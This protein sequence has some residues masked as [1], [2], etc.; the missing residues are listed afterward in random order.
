MDQ[1]YL[2]PSMFLQLKR[3]AARGIFHPAGSC[4]LAL[5]IFFNLVVFQVSD[6]HAQVRRSA[7]VTCDFTFQDTV[8]KNAPV[9]ITNLSQGA[10]N[11]FWQ[12]CPGT[13]LSFPSGISTGSIA[14]KL[15]LPFGISLEREGNMFYAF[16]TSAADSSVTRVAWVTSLINTPTFEKLNIPG[17]LTGKIAGIQVKNDN[18]SWY[19]FVANGSSLVRLDFGPSLGN[20]SPAV[21]T[22]AGSALMNTATGLVIGKDG[23]NWVG[24]CANYP[25]N[26]IVR[27]FWG[28]TLAADP[29][30][31]LIGNVGGLTRPMQPALIQDGS[32]WYLYVANTTSLAEIKF[33]TSLL[34]SPTG[35]N[36]GKLNWI[37]DNRGISSFFQCGH[38]YILIAN[39]DAI[40]NQL[41]QIHFKNGLAGPKSLIP[42]GNVGSLFETLALSE[43]MN[44]GDT[45]FCIA[46]NAL[47]S[48]T[49]LY[50][51]ACNDATIPVSTKFD[52]SPVIFPD[53][54]TYTI[55]L[56]VDPGLPTEQQVCKEIEVNS[57]S[58]DLGKDT[59]LCEGRSLA[60]DA[61]SGFDSYQW[62]TGETTRKITVGKAGNYSVT[63]INR[64]GCTASD[65]IRFDLNP[66]AYVSV[67][68][69][70]CYGRFYY[71]GGKL[72]S[73][74][75]TYIDSLATSKGCDSVLTTHLTVKQ[76]IILDLGNDTCMNPG[77]TIPLVAKGNLNASYTWQDGS[78]DSAYTVTQPGNFSVKVVVDHCDKTDAMVVSWC[79]VTVYFNVPN[80]FSPNGD[81]LNDLF[82]PSAGGITGFSM[83]IY[84]RW[85]EAVFESA[86]IENGW[87][88]T[89]KGRPCE[90]GVYVYVITY[91]TSQNPE[92]TNQKVNGTVTL[93]R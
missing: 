35:V 16:I 22:V 57:T 84:N 27:F 71:A 77:T 78:H 63:A 18:G 5:F 4:L 14:N 61:G 89:Y 31:S 42:L 81:G 24:F 70:I 12:F 43:T 76:E 69:S 88:G 49:V 38:P 86:N 45:T 15:G 20:L 2:K 65:A 1:G 6:C 80:A 11:Y 26:T 92:E 3:A 40:E 8:C 90:A 29:A 51:R 17:I 44:V 74:S 10:T 52:P 32:G 9:T 28:N 75:G 60:L 7:S 64:F 79:P 66:G 72:Q 53:S 87:D 30:M 56:T 48:L 19:G 39:H 82:L 36:L 55:K 46:I 54:G 21:S 33:G 68:T 58:L 91:G 25:A 73:S 62:S 83:I 59:S 34:N 85:G 93:V 47:P 13:P 23:I 41:F 50:F 37:T 67:D